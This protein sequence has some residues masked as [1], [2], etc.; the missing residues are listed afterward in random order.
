MI[1]IKRLKNATF[2]YSDNY[3]LLSVKTEIKSHGEGMM[4][5]RAEMFSLARFIL[6]VAQK[7]QKRKK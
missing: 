3:R 2:V 1:I 5:N 7:P 6:R 4:L